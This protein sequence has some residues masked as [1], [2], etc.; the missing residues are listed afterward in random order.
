MAVDL[1]VLRMPEIELPLRPDRPP[2]GSCVVG[3]RSNRWSPAGSRRARAV[4][5][6]P[7]DWRSA[8]LEDECVLMPKITAKPFYLPQVVAA[9]CRCKPWTDEQYDERERKG[10]E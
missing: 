3:A 9:S 4:G 8:A 7:T 5:G 1:I 2:D 6:N 10:N